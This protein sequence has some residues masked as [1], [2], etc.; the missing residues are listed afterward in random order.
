MSNLTNDDAR[1]FATQLMA[2]FVQERRATKS[3]V[4]PLAVAIARN[5]DVAS[6]S[7][8]GVPPPLYP[9]VFQAVIAECGGD[10]IIL[11]SETWMV[12]RPIDTPRSALPRDLSTALDRHEVLICRLEGCGMEVTWRSE[13]HANGTVDDPVAD[14]TPWTGG[15]LVGIAP[16]VN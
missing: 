2:R 9:T 15:R 16:Q 14:E 10:W 12:S 7:L 6:V 1:A 8:A 13:I 3:D 11:V 5:G 4:P